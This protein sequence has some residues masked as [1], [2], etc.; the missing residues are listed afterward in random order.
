MLKLNKENFIGKDALVKQKENGL[1]R[2]LVG[3]EL[4]DRGIGRHGYAVIKDS[5][6]IGHVTTGYLSPTL[7]KTIGFALIDAKY[8][9][10]GTEIF[11]KVR[12][13]ELK[14]IVVIKSFIVR[15]LKNK[16]E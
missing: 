5:E 13:K 6:E 7:N 1:T 3:Y 15:K 12:N 11:I 2:K 16:G 9:A 4:I 14:S 10:L 8:T